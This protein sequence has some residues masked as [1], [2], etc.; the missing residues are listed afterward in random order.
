MPIASISCSLLYLIYISKY[1]IFIILKYRKRV[2]TRNN[3][4]EDNYISNRLR[5]NARSVYGLI[6]VFSSINTNVCLLSLLIHSFG[7]GPESYGGY[8]LHISQT[9]V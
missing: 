4:F 8:K 6:R 7:P 1:I 9:W 2:L 5:L 3:F